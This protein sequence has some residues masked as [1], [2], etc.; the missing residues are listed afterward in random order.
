MS[1]ADEEKRGMRF[2]SNGMPLFR[3]SVMQR[4]SGRPDG[5]SIIITPISFKIYAL[6][7]ILIVS[8]VS[9]F[10]AFG[11]YTRT[12]T[13]KSIILPKNGLVAVRWPASGRVEAIFQEA[14]S[15]I[16][17]GEFLAEICAESIEQSKD[18]KQKDAMVDCAVNNYSNGVNEQKTDVHLRMKIES[19]ESGMIYRISSQDGVMVNPEEEFASIAKKGP[20]IVQVEVPGR[21]KEHI[22]IGTEFRVLLPD[23][24]SNDAST[25]I[26]RVLSVAI[27]PTE[28]Q[29]P[30]LPQTDYTYTVVAQ[31][32]MEASNNSWS[33]LLGRSVEVKVPVE[34]RLIYQWL[35]D[36][37]RKIM[38]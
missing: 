13:I 24:V 18:Q 1:D 10:V 14:G 3:E 25:L 37:L 28:N 35:F 6:I 12:D 38:G 29:N 33:D 26:A 17:K 20:L 27:A 36:P 19:P 9:S 7:A 31:V 23:G 11:S 2:G 30:F 22:K 8:A 15:M 32:E 34:S 21:T 4:Y 5:S 16:R